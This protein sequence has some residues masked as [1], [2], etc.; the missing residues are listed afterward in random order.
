MTNPFN[1]LVCFFLP[2]STCWFFSSGLHSISGALAWTLPCWLLLLADRF[3]PELKTQYSTRGAEGIYDGILYG[4]VF[5]QLLNILL[6]L[7]YV[8]QL[9]WQTSEDWMTGITNV[10]VIRF[11]VGT[12][13]GISGVVVAHELMHRNNG[14]MQGLGRIVLWSLCYDH[15]RVVHNQGHH[16]GVKLQDD[17]TTARLGESFRHYWQR[18]YYRQFLYAWEIEQQRLGAFTFKSGF[19]NQ[20]IQGLFIQLIIL[21]LSFYFYGWLATGLFLYQAFIAVRIIETINYVQHWG[22]EDKRYSNSFG[23]VSNT[24][25][26]RY[27]LLGLSNHIGHHQDEH[28]HFYE[29]PYSDQGPAMPY[30]YLVM[31]LWAKLHNASYQQMAIRQLEQYRTIS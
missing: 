10:I 7:N 15:F 8:S 4:L 23:W 2:V 11:L 9:P 13:S 12:G 20:V 5:L 22:L 6:M 31:N 3:S 1:Y 29:I 18:V 24:W 30:G 21:S 19:K 14:L 28:K 27:L 25:F 17:F 16:Q 26:T